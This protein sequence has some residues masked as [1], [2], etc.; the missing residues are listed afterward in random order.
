MNQDYVEHRRDCRLRKRLLQVLHA[1]RVRPESGWMTGRFAFDLVDGAR[2]GGDRFASDIH[3]LSLLR[4]LAHI[5]YVEE[6][7]DRTPRSPLTLESASFRITAAGSALVL[8][9]VEPDLLIT[10]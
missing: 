1:A 2:P 4:E 6:R 10:E 8:E 3:G 7:D 9:L 5:G